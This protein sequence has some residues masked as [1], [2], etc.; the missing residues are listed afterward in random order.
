MINDAKSDISRVHIESILQQ[1]PSHPGVYQYFNSDGK[2]IYIGKA[3]NLK[4]RV[5]S[6]F[7]RD[8]NVSNKVK[9]LVGK[10]IDIRY[11]V[12]DTESD[13]LL[14]ENNLIKK[15][16]PRYNILLKDD[17]TFP[18]LCVK[19]ERFP[20]IVYT[21]EF[22]NDGSEYFGPY[23]STV[24]VKTLYSLIKKLYPLRNCNYDLSDSNINAGKF[25][26]CLEYHLGNCKA[27]CINKQ[28]EQEYIA[29][30][31]TIKEI[32]KGNISDI[33]KYLE[34][35]MKQYAANLDFENAQ[36]IKQ[37]IEIIGNYQSKS[38]IVS[39]TLH[40]ID[41]FSI[42]EMDGSVS[43]NF[44]RVANGSIIQVH[45]IEV[46]RQL[47]EDLSEILSVAITDIRQKMFSNSKE[48]IVSIMPD[49]L[50]TGVKY[51]IPKLGDKLK[52]LE[53][54]ERNAKLFLAERLKNA[55]L[56][57][58]K[59]LE[60][61]NSVV[62]KLRLDLQLK[63]LPMHIECFDNSNIQ[64]TN[65]VAACV[66]FKNGKPSNKDYRHFNVKTV[67]G[68]DDFATMREIVYR[69]YKRML[70]EEDKLPDLIVIDGGKGQLGAAL[71]SLRLLNLT[72]KI[73]IIG[74][75]KK[76]EEIFRPG[77]PVPLYIDKNSSSLKLIQ[78][79]R[80]EAHRFGITFHRLKRSEDF[81]KSELDSIKGVGDKTKENLFKAFQSVDKIRKA[82]INDLSVI[83]GK[84][85]AK[86]VWDYFNK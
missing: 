86:I 56:F 28:S 57:S 77:D 70:D 52:L 9:V 48:I 32:L 31:K 17:K 37:K 45:S 67:E 80:N 38:A 85:K 18:W 6:Y 16:Q 23:T 65:A 14:L 64:G 79:L 76:L 15:Y 63:Y 1:L 12:V 60:K 8:S 42:A 83:I 69:R 68:P 7:Q 49:M 27:P 81:I 5:S 71:E 75:A 19:N 84:A 46:K 33:S 61:K 22:V 59:L 62:E 36:L 10:I 26:P 24:M 53:L 54:S 73:A 30:I 66:V 58:D 44:L 72:D 74:I 29:N 78:H 51:T 41:V 4:K 82:D 39:P 34:V 55:Q 40:N 3:K 50:L 20:R 43:V 35:L 47:E 13:A 2:I 25:K 11:I 21:R